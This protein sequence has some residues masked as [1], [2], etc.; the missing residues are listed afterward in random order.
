MLLLLFN[1]CHVLQL[2]SET[3]VVRRRMT[4]GW[5]ERWWPYNN[6]GRMW[7]KFPDICLTVEGKLRKKPQPE[8]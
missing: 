3:V 1:D 2:R 6:R 7:P 8:K 4:Y 5:D